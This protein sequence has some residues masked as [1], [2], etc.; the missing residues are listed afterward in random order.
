MS[1]VAA[2]STPVVAVLNMKGGVGK[3]T[4]AANVMRAIFD[5]KKKVQLVD[6]DPQMNL[7][8]LLVAP[9]AYEE[10]QKANRT[11]M[12][13][14]ESAANPSLFTVTSTAGATPVPKDLSHS[15][16]YFS[17]SPD[18]TIRLAAG[19]FGLVKYSLIDEADKKLNPVRGRFGQFIADC[20]ADRDIVCIDCNPSSSFLTVSALQVATHVV[21]PVKPDRYSVLGLE[22]LHRFV[23]GLPQLINKP[24]F[25]VLLNDIP[26]TQYDR[27]VERAVR[28]MP[29]FSRNTLSE[30]IHHSKIL[31]AHPKHTGF[32]A[33]RKGPYKA[34]AISNVKLVAAELASVLGV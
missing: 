9:K 5:T 11:M 18:V 33:E 12:T 20:R 17:Q 34:Q 31:S 30:V 3:T 2:S 22:M 19:D 28:S 27:T 13:V 29:A 14:M 16:R 24:K 7:T 15:M 21:V 6:L 4:I 10:L 32:A 26:R 23:S 25:V 1:Q 8:Q